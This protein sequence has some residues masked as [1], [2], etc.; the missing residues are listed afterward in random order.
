MTLIF[1]ARVEH[2]HAR[3]CRMIN[4]STQD[5]RLTLSW[6]RYV[7]AM[8]EVWIAFCIATLCM[9][10]YFSHLENHVLVIIG[11]ISMAIAYLFII[12]VCV[13]RLIEKLPIAA[14]MLLVPIA[15]LAILI[16]VV[17]LLPIIQKLR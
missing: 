6:K 4:D 12:I 8:L 10:I 2:G 17:S 7:F 16:L 5:I 9:G 14:L 11:A 1:L 3:L 15:P 13:K